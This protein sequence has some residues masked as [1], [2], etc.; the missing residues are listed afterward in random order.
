MI[1]ESIC[2]ILIVSGVATMSAV[3]QCFAPRPVLQLLYGVE[4]SDPITLLL[5]RHWGV[6]IGLVGALLV[7]S[8]VDPG[9][10]TPVLIVAGI[11]KMMFS[12]LVFLGPAP[13]TSVGTLAATGDTFFALLYVLYF[14]GL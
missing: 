13:R 12:G 1:N 9:V 10:R 11:E 8:A 7:Y 4:T 5:A 2:P 14:V 3:G 6:L